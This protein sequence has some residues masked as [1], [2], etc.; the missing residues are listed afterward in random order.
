MASSS[1]SLRCEVVAAGLIVDGDGILALLH[2]FAQHGRDILVAEGLVGAAEFDLLVF[3]CRL[4]Q[5]DSADAALVAGLHGLLDDGRQLLAHGA[6]SLVLNG[7]ADAH[8]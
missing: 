8:G 1:R 3:Q 7:P 4:D 2:H 6:T 5:S